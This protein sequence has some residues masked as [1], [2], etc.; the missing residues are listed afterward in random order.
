MMQNMV[1]K[2]K[3]AK[4]A[5]KL[6]NDES[7]KDE[8]VMTIT[9]SECVENQIGMEQIGENVKLDFRMMI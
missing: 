9:F 1:Q 8:G 4:K 3:K 5:K 6:Y 2:V 7:Y